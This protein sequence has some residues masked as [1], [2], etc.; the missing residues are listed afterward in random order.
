MSLMETADRLAEE[1]GVWAARSGYTVDEV[2]QPLWRNT[3]PK[4]TQEECF[5]ER[6]PQ[7]A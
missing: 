7:K 6:Q 4:T 5:L 2:T 1:V 3:R